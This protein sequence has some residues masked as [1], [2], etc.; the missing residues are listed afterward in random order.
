MI[1]VIIVVVVIMIAVIRGSSIGVIVVVGIGFDSTEWFKKSFSFRWEGSIC[2][3]CG[4]HSQF[5]RCPTY[6][7]IIIV[8]TIGR[9]SNG[10][11]LQYT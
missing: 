4:Y 6:R 11:L 7:I 3:I 10:W 8:I 5:I 9:V 1:V 2:S